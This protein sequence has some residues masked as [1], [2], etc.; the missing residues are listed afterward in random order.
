MPQPPRLIPREGLKDFGIT[1]QRSQIDLLVK[2]GR[3]PAPIKI[4]G[5]KNFWIA[6]EIESY[7]RQMTEDRNRG[8][9]PEQ[10]A[11]VE[12]VQQ[13]KP[14]GASSAPTV[15]EAPIF[16]AP[17]KP[18]ADAEVLR[19]ASLLAEKIEELDV[20]VDHISVLKRA[21]KRAIHEAKK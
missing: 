12:R 13:A 20:L 7:I 10:T 4:G 1:H 11:C 14:A 6:D 2:Q 21:L 18:R 17:P 15:S 16:T 5:I 3:F 8:L 9:T 19:I